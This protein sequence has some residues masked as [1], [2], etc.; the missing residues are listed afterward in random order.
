MM[1]QGFEKLYYFR[2]MVGDR[3]EGLLAVYAGDWD[4]ATKKASEILSYPGVKLEKK[5][6]R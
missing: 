3:C 4:Y 5:Y 2:I 1:E 6:G